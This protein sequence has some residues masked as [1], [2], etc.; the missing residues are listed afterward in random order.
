MVAEVAGG[1][2]SGSLALLADAGHMLSDTGALALSLFAIWI[3]QRPPNPKRTYGYYRVEILTALLHAS[4]LLVIAVFLLFEAWERFFHPQEVK[5][6]IMLAVASGGLVINLAGLWILHG[7]TKDNL[8]V[9]GA[10]LHVLTDALGSVGAI[11]SAILVWAFH[12]QA[13]DAVA[14]VAISLLVVYS[15]W[16]LLGQAVAI[17]MES[18]PHHI[19]VDEVRDAMA[20]TP[21]VLEV[22]DLHIWSI[23]R[24]LE[25]LSGHVV[26]QPDENRE[27]LLG[28]LQHTLKTRFGIDHVTIQIEVAGCDAGSVCR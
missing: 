7:G 10:W 27:E 25:C 19:D 12:I 18:A 11:I 3:A 16:P 24:G 9:R 14:S 17:L 28:S 20:G 13:A 4:S 2:L 23:T 21:G 6:P 1:I 8:N 26:T 15:A 22:H 5:G